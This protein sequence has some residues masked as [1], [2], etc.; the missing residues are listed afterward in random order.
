M[1]QYN[2]FFPNSSYSTYCL[3]VKPIN[4]KIVKMPRGV[5]SQRYRNEV[6]GDV[7]KPKIIKQIQM[8]IDA[9]DMKLR[10]VFQ[11]F[12]NKLRDVISKDRGIVPISKMTHL[13]INVVLQVTHKKQLKIVYMKIRKS[14]LYLV[15]FQKEERGKIYE[16]MEESISPLFNN[17]KVL[18]YEGNYLS[19]LGGDSLN[20]L[21]V[22]FYS[23][24]H[25]AVDLIDIPESQ[26]DNWRKPLGLMAVTLCESARFNNVFNFI[27]KLIVNQRDQV[28]EPWA[29]QMFRN[30]SSMS[31]DALALPNHVVVPARLTH[32][33]LSSFAFLTEA[34]LAKV[35]LH[36]YH[37]PLKVV[38]A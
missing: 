35:C 19:L 3:K 14:D 20:N 4:P 12:L 8:K 36:V 28:L 5:V 34:P 18:P 13:F 27:N 24:I 17:S 15:A 7:L 25:A 30:W 31:K 10:R 11:V 6:R 37:Y 33:Q 16:L 1:K 23:L 22:G 29:P 2:F 32:Q 38:Q 26:L 9:T 21:Q